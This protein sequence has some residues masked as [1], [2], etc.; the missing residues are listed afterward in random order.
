MKKLIILVIAFLL[1]VNLLVL[2]F[3]SS[4]EV[5]TNPAGEVITIAEESFEIDAVLIKTVLT[6]GAEHSERLRLH[7]SLSFS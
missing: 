1:L 6:G 5:N 2:G 3:V 4:Q 7:S